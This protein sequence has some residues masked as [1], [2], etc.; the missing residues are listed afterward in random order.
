MAPK[1][2]APPGQGPAAKPPTGGNRA[3][4]QLAANPTEAQENKPKKTGPLV[5]VHVLDFMQFGN[6][7]L[8]SGA[9]ADEGADDVQGSAPG[10]RP[11]SLYTGDPARIWKLEAREQKSPEGICN[12]LEAFR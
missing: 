4:K 1:G 6:G 10:H 7:P 12:L 2:A 9:L 8:A 11:G 5:G 3:K